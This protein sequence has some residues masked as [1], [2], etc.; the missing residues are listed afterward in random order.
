MQ[1]LRFMMYQHYSI[2][3]TLLAL[4]H[5]YHTSFQNLHKRNMIRFLRMLEEPNGKHHTPQSALNYWQ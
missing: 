3:V 5:T 1:I 4:P 2:T